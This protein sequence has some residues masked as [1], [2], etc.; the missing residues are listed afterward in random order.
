M[1]GP[2]RYAGR[3]GAA[4]AERAPDRA[5]GGVFGQAV[6]QRL[7]KVGLSTRVLAPNFPTRCAACG[8]ALPRSSRRAG[9]R[10]SC[11]TAECQRT[12]ARPQTIEGVLRQLGRYGW[13]LVRTPH[14]GNSTVFYLYVINGTAPALWR[15]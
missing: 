1:V 9:T 6:Q 12:A 5:A 15:V 14:T 2:C 3:A 4:R 7:A 13:E 10:H 11:P 8:A